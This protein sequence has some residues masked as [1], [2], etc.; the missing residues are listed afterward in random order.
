V[1][2]RGEPQS[3]RAGDEGEGGGGDGAEQASKQPV[4]AGLQQVGAT[5]AAHGMERQPELE[6][7]RTHMINTC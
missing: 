6:L 3:E 4:V 2:S 7:A 1:S 5:L